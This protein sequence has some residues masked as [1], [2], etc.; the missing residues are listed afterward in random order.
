MRIPALARIAAL[1]CAGAACSLDQLTKSG[2]SSTASDGGTADGGGDASVVGAGCGVEGESGAQLC[3]ATALCPNVVVDGETLPHCGFRIRGAIVDLV[4]A[5]GQ[6]LC[7]MGVYTTCAQAA[8]LLTTQTEQQVCIQVNEN[9][10]TPVPTSASSGS[11]GG[12]SGGGGG[13]GSGNNKPGCDKAC[14]AECG[15]GS[16]CASVCGC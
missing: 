6:A 13:S 3:R 2:A 4:C 10:C 15:G 12:S 11:G 16:A 8:R 5:C 1:A 7:S 14:V 9:R